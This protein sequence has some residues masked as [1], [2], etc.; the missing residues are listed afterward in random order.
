MISSW[1]LTLLYVHFI[2]FVQ[3][4]SMENYQPSTFTHIHTHKKSVV[5][6]L[7]FNFFPQFY[8]AGKEKVFPSSRFINQF[9]SALGITNY[10]HHSLLPAA[11]R[12]HLHVFNAGSSYLA[13]TSCLSQSEE[14][15]RQG[16]KEWEV[17]KRQFKPREILQP[18]HIEITTIHG[19]H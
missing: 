3:I 17:R 4:R 18:L 16:G 7:S 9:L 14:A 1:G 8:R 2:K 19:P 11:T 10:S 5:L 12:Q 13:I 6:H 15:S